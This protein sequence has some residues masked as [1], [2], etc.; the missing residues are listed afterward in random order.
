M[1]DEGM[2]VEWSK[3]QARAHRWEE[4]VHLTL[5]EMRRTIAY[6]EWKESWWVGVQHCESECDGGVVHGREAYAR[7]Q[8]YLCK[9]LAE[10]FAKCWLPK[11]QSHKISGKWQDKYAYVLQ[12]E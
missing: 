7:K 8:A 11:V 9:V 5:E 12:L 3:A 1:L 10:G 4:E 6:Y 2:R